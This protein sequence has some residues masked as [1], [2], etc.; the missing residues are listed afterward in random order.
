MLPQKLQ[1]GRNQNIGCT[2]HLIAP[3]KCQYPD[4]SVHR[5]LAKLLAFG[6]FRFGQSFEPLS[7]TLHVRLSFAH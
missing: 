4:Y 5:L 7:F 3:L 2:H 1:P 6:V